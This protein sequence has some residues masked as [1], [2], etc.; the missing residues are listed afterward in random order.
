MKVKKALVLLAAW[1]FAAPACAQ[2]DLDAYLRRDRYERM[3]ISPTGEFIAVTVPL[4][5]RTV[6]AILRLSDKTI[7]AKAAG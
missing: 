3:K 2:V 4:E 6:L 7:A 5:D 1:M